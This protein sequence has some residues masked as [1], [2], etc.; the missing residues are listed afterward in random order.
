MNDKIKELS[1]KIR[2]EGYEK[3]QV[4][5]KQ[6]LEHA[7][8]EAEEIRQ[9]ARLEAEAIISE[10]KEVANEHADIVNADLKLSV[11]Q[12][13]LNL[14]QN[15]TDLLITKVVDGKLE[16]SMNDPNFIANLIQDTVRN[17]K[18]YQKDTELEILL[19]E[20]TYNSVINQFKSNAQILLNKGFEL[21]VV[22]GSN[23]GFEIQPKNGHYKI[24][25][26]DEAFDAFLRASLRPISKQFLFEDK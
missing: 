18:E 26:T 24:C 16:K 20:D 19:S 1:L 12:I 7:N 9:N 8:M 25:M 23:A 15:I 11:E 5:A 17:W 22:S 4:E 13:L 10:A 3:A 6:L 14:R 21:K 2:K